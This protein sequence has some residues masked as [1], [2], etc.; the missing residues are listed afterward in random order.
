MRIIDHLFSNSTSR[1]LPISFFTRIQPI[2][3][4]MLQVNL[5]CHYVHKADIKRYEPCFLF[6]FLFF[7]LH[8]NI[9]L[10][11]SL[12]LTL[13]SFHICYFSFNIY[14]LALAF[15]PFHTYP[16]SHDNCPALLYY[17]QL[18][19]GWFWMRVVFGTLPYSV[20]ERETT[21]KNTHTAHGY[22]IYICQYLAGKC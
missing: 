16:V 19:Y 22:V 21:T 2:E 18:N 20:I 15:I 9:S 5:H 11:L 14:S 12:T 10:S 6:F 8:F 7:F 17:N 3:C 4:G 13:A 1:C